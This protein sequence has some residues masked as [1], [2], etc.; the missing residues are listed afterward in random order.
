[1]NGWIVKH[2]G[3][4]LNSRFL[5][6]CAIITQVAD[7]RHIALNPGRRIGIVCRYMEY[8]KSTNELVN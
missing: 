7:S 8:M 1:M 5:E 3:G 2:K 6:K 4:N